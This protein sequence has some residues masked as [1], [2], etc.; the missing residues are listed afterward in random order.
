MISLDY[1]QIELRVI[2]HMAGIDALIQAFHD[3]EDIHAITASQVFGVPVEGMDP[4]MRRKAKAI[5]F[6]IIYGISA[7]GL[8]RQLG[9]EQKEA[10]A[11]I[12]AYFERY[13]GIK[14]YMERLKAE[15][16]KSGMVETLFGRRIHLPGIN[17]KNHMTRNYAERQAI[18]AP[19][20]GTAADI[21]KR[22]MIRVPQALQ[23][24][25]LKAEMLLQVHDELLFEAPVAEVDGV[26]E[27]ISQVMGNA[28]G[29]AGSLSVPLDVEAGVGDNWDEA[30]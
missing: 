8:A 4:M 13:P 24:K 9:I 12:E 14:D 25:K 3:G 30:H 17:D 27:I 2:A 22:A 26:I 20:Q 11:Y 1:S 16:R 15:C 5:N 7:F 21:I 29:P 10:K 23:Q 6:G 28:V 19:V 18:N